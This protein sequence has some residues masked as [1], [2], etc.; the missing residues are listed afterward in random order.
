MRLNIPNQELNFSSLEKRKP[1]KPPH[2][3]DYLG[4]LSNGA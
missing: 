4:D 1:T 2:F 3:V